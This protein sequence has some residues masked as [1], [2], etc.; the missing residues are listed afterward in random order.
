MDIGVDICRWKCPQ[1][2]RHDK[3]HDVWDRVEHSDTLYIW[4]I[5]QEEEKTELAGECDTIMLL[6]VVQLRNACK[7]T[8]TKTNLERCGRRAGQPHPKKR[9]RVPSLPWATPSTGV[10]AGCSGVQL[11]P[12]R[13]LARE[14]RVAHSPNSAILGYGAP[15]PRSATV[16][17]SRVFEHVLP[18]NH[19]LPGSV[20]G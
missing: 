7:L 17:Q 5:E 9:D 8:L 6:R 16:V 15:D 11:P 1:G 12:L 18:G 10:I 4:V 20:Q 19:M 13:R 2:S 3:H 14:D